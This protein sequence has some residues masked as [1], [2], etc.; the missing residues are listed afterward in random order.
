MSICTRLAVLT[1]AL[2]LLV[3]LAPAQQY[4]IIDLGTFQGGSVSQG[5]AINVAGQVAGYARFSNYNAH[6]FYWTQKTGLVDLGSIPPKT[7]FSVAQAINSLADIVGYSDYNEIQDQH[8]VLWQHSTGTFVDLGTLNG[9]TYSQAN[10]INDSGMI[11]GFSNGAVN[12]MHEVVWDKN[13]IHDLGALSGGYGQGIAINEEG[14][15]TGFSQTQDGIWHATLWN[16]STGLKA[17]PMFTEKDSSASGNSINNLGQVAGGSGNVAVLWENNQNHTPR[18]LGVLSGAGWSTAFAI[19]DVGQVVGWS[20]FTAFI[21]TQK[22]G[23]VDLNTLIPPNSGWQLILPTSINALGQ[24]VG[25][26][27]INGASHGFLLTPI[28]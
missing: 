16:K 12:S 24:I 15:V 4:S 14:E 10:G 23:M 18:S 17:L 13:G 22:T 19:N 20:G 28:Q 11:A 27:N 3:S 6:G 8:A 1:T 5:Q 7:N 2:L 21:W 26:G 9:G 25:Q